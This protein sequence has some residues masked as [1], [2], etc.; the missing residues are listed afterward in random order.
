MTTTAT[1]GSDAAIYFW[2]YLREYRK[3]GKVNK[4]ILVVMDSANGLKYKLCQ[5]EQLLLRPRPSSK[6]RYTA[7]QSHWKYTQII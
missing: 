5:I 7:L 4:Y 1:N 6:M 2:K 3:S